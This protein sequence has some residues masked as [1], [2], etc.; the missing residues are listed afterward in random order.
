MCSLCGSLQSCPCFQAVPQSW[1]SR[2]KVLRPEFRLWLSCVLLSVCSST[3][4]S[5]ATPLVLKGIV[6]KGLL[7]HNLGMFFLYAA[8]SFLVAIGLKLATWL[9]AH[10]QV[11][12]ENR[13]FVS[14]LR[15]CLQ[16]FYASPVRLTQEEGAGF[17]LSRIFDE[18]STA[19]TQVSKISVTWSASLCSFLVSLTIA[20][21]LSVSGT[22]LLLLIVPALSILARRVMSSSATLGNTMLDDRANLRDDMAK[23]LQAHRTVRTFGLAELVIGKTLTGAQQILAKQV[24]LLGISKRYEVCSGVLMTA[25]ESIVF[26]V[27]AYQVVRGHLSIGGFLAFMGVFWNL[28]NAGGSLLGQLPELSVLLSQMDRVLT[29]PQRLGAAARAANL[30]TTEIS[31]LHYGDNTLLELREAEIA[32]GKAARLAPMNMALRRGERVLVRGENGAGK[33]T[34]LNTLSGYIPLSAGE[35]SAAAAVEVSVMSNPFHFASGSLSFHVLKQSFSAEKAA[36]FALA[37]ERLGLSEKEDLDIGIALS[38]G[39]RQKAQILVTLFKDADVYFFDEPLAHLD[40]DSKEDVM[41]LILSMTKDKALMMIIHGDPKYDR[42]F[43]KKIHLSSC[44]DRAHGGQ[45]R[46]ETERDEDWN[47][48]VMAIAESVS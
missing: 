21:Y 45:T 19:A 5:A 39:E 42:A 38:A 47:V 28:L 29:F 9:Q 36:R 18:T 3:L 13:M 20:F 14:D 37:V 32:S 26:G 27:G 33:T 1:R 44:T 41:E 48:P 30:K 2:F 7:K 22:V 15:G 31:R 8:A 10:M 6:D 34:L 43:E 4:M 16:A 23:S 35:R 17:Y 25:G 24:K 46:L 40:G 11:R 12:L